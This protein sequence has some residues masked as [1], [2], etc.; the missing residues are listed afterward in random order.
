MRPRNESGGVRN[1]TRHDQP[2]NAEELPAA[3]ETLTTSV[4][5]VRE[6]ARRSCGPSDL[7]RAA[8]NMGILVGGK[9][10][11]P[12]GEASIEMLVGLTFYEPN[13]RGIRPFDRFL[14]GRA[15]S[16]PERERD[17]ARR[18]DQAVFSIF[19]RA[20]KH[21]TMGT[22]VKDI[23]DNDRRAIARAPG[24][25]RYFRNRWKNAAVGRCEE[26]PRFDASSTYNVSMNPPALR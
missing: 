19:R 8:Q 3:I 1:D 16:L 20:E 7:K 4:T 26:S 5:S 25:I 21:E 14:S 15:L 11:P 6:A 12:H 24:S 18:M 13:E 2:M 23:P 17:I 22:W 9:I 10:D